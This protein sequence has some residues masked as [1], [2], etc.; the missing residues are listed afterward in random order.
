MRALAALP[1]R[2]TKAAA[3]PSARRAFSQRP[4]P[5]RAPMAINVDTLH[6]WGNAYEQ[7]IQE[8]GS[9]N[10]T[11][12]SS[13]LW[14]RSQQWLDW[15][16]WHMPD[17]TIAERSAL[18]AATSSTSEAPRRTVATAQESL[19]VA[20][21]ETPRQP[22]PTESEE[23][24][25]ADRSDDDPLPPGLHHQIKLPAGEAGPKPTESEEDVN[26]DRSTDDPL[27]P[28]SHHKIR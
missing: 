7:P 17:K 21:K 8:D 1:A 14:A 16:H 3:A 25:D 24:V 23:D 26:A 9:S 12:I 13:G 10:S 22:Q 5:L 19:V 15:S 11:E 20:T 28:E 18:L 2:I 27:P 4:A 6:L